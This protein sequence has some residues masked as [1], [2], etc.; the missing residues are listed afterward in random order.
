[1]ARHCLLL[2]EMRCGELGFEVFCDGLGRLNSQP[3][4]CAMNDAIVA[5]KIA[6][7]TYADYCGVRMNWA[8][9][10]GDETSRAC[11]ENGSQPVYCGALHRRR[12]TAAPPAFASG[13]QMAENTGIRFG[14][15]G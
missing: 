14:R 5:E 8:N 7:E 3:S 9:W 10:C 15:T 13:I 11:G 2:T 1:M 12:S 6:W 4:R